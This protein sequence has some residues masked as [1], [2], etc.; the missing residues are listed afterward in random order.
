[1]KEHEAGRALGS[2]RG[3]EMP[4]GSLGSTKERDFEYVS[5]DGI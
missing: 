1:M 3:G 4:A 2:H 5:V